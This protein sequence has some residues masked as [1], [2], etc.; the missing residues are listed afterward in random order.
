MGDR[1]I[2][3]LCGKDAGVKAMLLLPEGAPVQPTGME[4]RIIRSLWELKEEER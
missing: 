1:P 3:I 4:D 2:D